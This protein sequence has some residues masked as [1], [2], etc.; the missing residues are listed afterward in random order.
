MPQW[1]AENGK[2]KDPVVAQFTRLDVVSAGFLYVLKP[3][4][5]GSNATEGMDLIAR[6]EQAGKEQKLPFSM[7]L[8]RLPVEGMCTLDQD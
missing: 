5:I 6:R 1:L 8:F 3:R 2:Y 7:S 4:E